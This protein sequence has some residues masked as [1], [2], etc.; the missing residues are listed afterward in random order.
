MKNVLNTGYWSKTDICFGNSLELSVC[1][2]KLNTVFTISI[3]TDRHSPRQKGII[4]IFFL[5]CD[6]NLYYGYSLEVPHRGTS[7]EYTQ[8]IFVEK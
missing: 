2:A 7:N 3:Q 6:E 5:F 8:H 1:P 4:R